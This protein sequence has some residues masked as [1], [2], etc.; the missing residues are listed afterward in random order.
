MDRAK[1]KTIFIIV[2]VIINI[3]LLS[4]LISIVNRE[5]RITKAAVNQMESLLIENNIMLDRKIIPKVSSKINS[6][7]IDRVTGESSEFVEALLGAEYERNDDGSFAAQD[8]VLSIDNDS[9]RFIDNSPVPIEPTR[10]YENVCLEY[11]RKIGIKSDLYKYKSAN[12]SGDNKKLIFVS[13][14]DGYEIFDSYISLEISENGICGMQAKNLILDSENADKKNK[15]VDINSVLVDLIKEYSTGNNKITNIV[16]I[17]L[18]YYIGKYTVDY[19][20]VLSIPAWQIVTN[21]GRI[22]CYDARN[23]RYIPE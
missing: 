4:F 9:I 16:S 21:D 5:H 8:K 22:Y 12:P 23:G 17:K 3:S 11:M 1:I 15:A 6:F 14:Y 2:L 7:Y 19:N 10:N 18:G 20:R 13:E